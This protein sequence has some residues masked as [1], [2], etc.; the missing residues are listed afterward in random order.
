MDPKMRVTSGGGW[1][2][3]G[4]AKTDQKLSREKMLEGLRDGTVL[5]ARLNPG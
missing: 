3:K 2:G 1:R 4:L 5:L